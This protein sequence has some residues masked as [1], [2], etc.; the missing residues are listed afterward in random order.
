MISIRDVFEQMLPENYF[1][2]D[3]NHNTIEMD[4]D[5]FNSIMFNI[6]TECRIYGKVLYTSYSVTYTDFVKFREMNGWKKE[7]LIII[8]EYAKYVY[9]IIDE[10]IT[11]I[12]RNYVLT[13]EKERN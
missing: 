5:S 12:V 4:Y 8:T 3:V 9:D 7:P 10:E 13:K 1:I 11:R 6:T 2:D